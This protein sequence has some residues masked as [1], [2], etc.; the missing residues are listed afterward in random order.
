M[1]AHSLHALFTKV[2]PSYEQVFVV[3]KIRYNYPNTDYLHLL[4]AP[5]IA[6]NPDIKIK[7]ISALQ[8]WKPVLFRFT[9]SKSIL[10]YHWLEFQDYKSAL[11]MVYKILCLWK[12]KLFGGKLVW[13]I[14][15]LKPHDG[16]WLSIHQILHKWMAGK[17]ELILVHSENVINE[18][19]QLY[20]CDKNK[21]EVYAHPKFPA[22]LKK[23]DEAHSYLFEKF[24][25]K[26][27]PAK[28]VLGSVGAISNYKNFL[29]TIKL[30]KEIDGNFVYLIFG[31]VKKGQ[32]E[33]HRTL[34]SYA[35]E[36]DWLYYVPGFVDEND[37]PFI[38]SSF[39]ICPFNFEEITT[40]GGV[41][42]SL[43]YNRII[44]APRLGSLHDKEDLQ[45][46]H[47]FS[48]QVEF[49]HILKKLIA[50]H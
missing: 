9:K 48:D 26:I 30:L 4:Y 14:H 2:L 20:E 6:S 21:I 24:G 37:L 27:H 44:V 16:K 22:E 33:L 31:Y 28:K 18:V 38:M 23:R 10:H 13:T 25:L 45:Q 11:G 34:L 5:L 7:S 32:S 41:E 42:L 3:P 43:A 40:S 17:A 1:T 15:N 36:L 46:V 8:H 50:E 39:D 12:Y 49:M 29:S 19:S 35:E 47:L